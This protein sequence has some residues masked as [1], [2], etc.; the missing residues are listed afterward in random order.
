MRIEQRV[1][2]TPERMAKGGLRIHT[3]D[4]GNYLSCLPEPDTVLAVLIERGKIEPVMQDFADEFHA[5]RLAF[6]SP[7]RGGRGAEGSGHGGLAASRYLW[8]SKRM[9]P[10]RFALALN[11]STPG[12]EPREELPHASYRLAFE[13]L[14]D[15]MQQ[16]RKEVTVE[17]VAQNI[18]RIEAK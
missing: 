6:L 13:Q 12:W 9:K 10:A 7:V 17:A 1:T 2:P 3:D 11:A 4:Q 16:A 5:W 8:L 14:A 15:W 18:A